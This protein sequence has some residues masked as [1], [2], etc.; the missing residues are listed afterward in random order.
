MDMDDA[1][2]AARARWR[3]R[4][5]MHEL[6]A[7]LKAFVDAAYADL[8]DADKSRFEVLLDLPDPELY[9]YL[10]GRSEAADADVARLV[11]AI[12]ASL[13]SSG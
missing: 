7:V 12:G 2:R 11:K 8:S 1:A 4:R 13:P 9:A 10:A 3:C 5:G 6:D